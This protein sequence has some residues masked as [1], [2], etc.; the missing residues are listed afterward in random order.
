MH[1][2]YR[3]SWKSKL[4]KLLLKCLSLGERQLGIKFKVSRQIIGDNLEK[5]IVD[6]IDGFTDLICASADGEFA[7]NDVDGAI[8]GT[9]FA[10]DGSTF[11]ECSRT[12]SLSIL[13]ILLSTAF[14]L[15]QT[16]IHRL[17]S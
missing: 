16:G 4:G 11:C 5:S 1:G 6:E 15:T 8:E 13:C 3:E 2:I 10:A 17:I 9:A 14:Q 7:F 12:K